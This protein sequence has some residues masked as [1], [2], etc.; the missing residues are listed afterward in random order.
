M[1][2]EVVLVRHFEREWKNDSLYG[3]RNAHDIII[4]NDDRLPSI[5]NYL[6]AI[7]SKGLSISSPVTCCI[8][9]LKHY[10]PEITPEIAA[11]FTAYHSGDLENEK[12]KNVTK[13]YPGYKSASYATRFVNPV[14]NEEPLFEQ[15]RRIISGFYR[16]NNTSSKERAA[17]ICTHF[18]TLN[19]L[20]SCLTG[21]WEAERMCSG[22]FDVGYGD[23]C[24]FIRTGKDKWIFQRS[25]EFL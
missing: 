19:V 16:I 4:P 17:L 18:S 5:T 10:L 23:I 9:T 13:K 14:Y 15:F 11:E 21:V 1:L 2:E 6:R 24:R 22:S 3:R 20:G 25:T 8:D 7:S 12:F